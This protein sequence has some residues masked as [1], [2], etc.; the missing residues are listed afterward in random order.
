MSLGT[1]TVA[2]RV[3]SLTFKACFF[4]RSNASLAGCFYYN[5]LH[6]NFFK[7]T[8]VQKVPYR[9]HEPEDMKVLYVLFEKKG[10]GRLVSWILPMRYL[11]PA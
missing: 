8:D 9:Q 4:K 2:Q 1:N 7:K 11:G 10:K 3:S 6:P 5:Y